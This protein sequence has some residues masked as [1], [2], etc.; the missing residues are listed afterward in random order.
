M[1]SVKLVQ[2][3]RKDFPF[4]KQGMIYL[5]TAASAQKPSVVLDTMKSFYE[6]KYANVHRGVYALADEATKLS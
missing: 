6:S 2:D 1:A 3:V 4:F 5:D